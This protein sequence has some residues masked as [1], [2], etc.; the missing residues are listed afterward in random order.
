MNSQFLIIIILLSC[1][2]GVCICSL[3]LS[4]CAAFTLGGS[5]EYYYADGPN[6]TQTAIIISIDGTDF[7]LYGNYITGTWDKTTGLVTKMS[8]LGKAFPGAT[9]SLKIDPKSK[10]LLYTDVNNTVYTMINYAPDPN[11]V[12]NWFNSTV[13]IKLGDDMSVTGNI[14]GVQNMTDGTDKLE[15]T[16]YTPTGFYQPSGIIAEYTY[17]G[18]NGTLTL[19]INQQSLI[20]QKK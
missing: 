9:R 15:Y 8:V 14:P 10:K 7:K 4:C 2:W 3:S 5:T 13:N 17:D 20:L 16:Y 1:C 11:L 19:T 6:N 18:N 12:G